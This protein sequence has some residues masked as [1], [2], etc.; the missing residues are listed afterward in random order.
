MLWIIVLNMFAFGCLS[1]SV[2]FFARLMIPKWAEDDFLF[3]SPKLGRIKAI[4]RSGRITG[5]IYNMTGS[6]FHF[7]EK[8][9]KRILEEM[10]SN[11]WWWRKFGARFIWLDDVY[12]YEITTEVVEKED[13]SLEYKKEPASSIFHDGSYPMT[14]LLYTKEGLL[15]RVKIRVQTTTRD[16]STALR[17]P[18]SW[19]I[20]MFEGIIAHFRRLFGNKEASQLISVDPTGVKPKIDAEEIGVIREDLNTDTADSISMEKKC[21]QYIEG[22]DVVDID[23]A[24]PEDEELFRKP[25]KA[26]QESQTITAKALA[27]KEAANNKAKAIRVEGQAVADTYQAQCRALGGDTSA[28]VADKHSKMTNL[29]TLVVNQSKQAQPVVVAV[30]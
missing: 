9:G 12:T 14:V 13:G 17:L 20:P 19:T 26:M 2:Y 10:E 5:F 21:G 24:R 3:C 22:L 6:G 25:Y 16:A 23:F 18:V 30:K 8:T 27:E 4:R 11:N 7:D 1:T 28:I 15:L 29:T